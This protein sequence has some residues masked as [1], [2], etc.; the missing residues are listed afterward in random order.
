MSP[1]NE[2]MSKAK[3]E[4]R[5]HIR[6]LQM[7]YTD[8]ELNIRSQL[9][10]N[11]LTEH[12]ALVNASTVLSYW[13]MPKEL[14][15]TLVNKE[16]KK[17]KRVLLPV[18]DGNDLILKE[19]TSEQDF[20]TSN[21]YSICEPIGPAFNDYESIDVVIVPGV[22]FTENGHRCG[23]GKGYYDR[24]LPKMDQAHTIGVCFDFQLLENV[25]TD[26]HDVLLDEVIAF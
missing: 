16:L 11:R 23:H 24:L 5:R 4:L 19:F 9:V 7:Q 18:I 1:R 10:L 6:D 26:S 12:P 25:P 2:S 13:P 8:E 17:S 22:A 15:T 20:N 3:K 21:K 14:N